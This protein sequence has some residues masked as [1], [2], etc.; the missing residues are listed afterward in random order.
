MLDAR[1]RGLVLG[2]L[3][4]ATLAAAAWVH[5]RDDADM[6]EVAQ[7]F[8]P[9]KDAR[10]TKALRKNA[11]QVSAESGVPQVHLDKLDV[12]NIGEASKDPFAVPHPKVKKQAKR[13]RA[14]VVVARTPPP[15]PPGAPPLPFRYMGK[16]V[17]GDDVSVFLTHGSRN[18]VVH[19]GETIDSKYRVDRIGESVMTLT[20]LPL[21]QQQTLA[22]G[23]RQ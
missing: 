6:H 23:E 8:T 16:L 19:A 22:L 14:P 2:G 9:P 7:P 13:K 20:Y 5:D 4:T 15:A 11:L 12:R 18:L 10:E 21:N 3:L 1:Q 17:D